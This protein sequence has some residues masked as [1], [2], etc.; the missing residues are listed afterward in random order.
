M[1]LSAVKISYQSYPSR[2]TAALS[3]QIRADPGQR[4][5]KLPRKY[6]CGRTR[7]FAQATETLEQFPKEHSFRR[8]LGHLQLGAPTRSTAARGL[9]LRLVL[10][11]LLGSL[12]LAAMACTNALTEDDI[13]RIVRE[14]VIQGPQGEP[15]PA[16]LQG[17]R[18]VQGATGLQGEPGPQGERGL[19]GIPGEQGPAGEPGP[20]GSVGSPGEKGEKGDAGT[21]GPQ[22]PQGDQ[23]EQGPQGPAGPAALVVLTQM[24]QPTPTPTSSPTAQVTPTPEQTPGPTPT[25]APTLEPTPTPTASPTLTPEPPN[26]G[27]GCSGNQVDINSASATQLE[28]IKHVGPARAQAIIQTRPFSSVDDLIRVSGI[29]PAR[30]SDIKQQGLACV[31]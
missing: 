5:F 19:S 22:G 16:G 10:A 1:T 20:R 18:G 21:Q 9:Y 17:E 15:G 31:G 24:P 27:T 25:S 28:Q 14:E 6:R 3:R 13:R 23:G 12:A 26:G 8:T 7:I 11:L 4:R 29:G 2:A 30:L